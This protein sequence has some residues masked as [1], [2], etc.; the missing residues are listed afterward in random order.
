MTKRPEL[1]RFL[2]NVVIMLG[3]WSLARLMAIPVLWAAGAIESGA[4]RDSRQVV[5]E[6]AWSGLAACVA[7]AIGLYFADTA[8]PALWATALAVLVLVSLWFPDV[9]NAKAEE[10]FKFIA[11]AVG[12]ALLALVGAAAGWRVRQR[13]PD[14]RA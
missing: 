10:R 6:L 13:V 9:W 5:V 14:A 4:E 8:S 2:K 7:G 1:T 12:P 3:A 11:G